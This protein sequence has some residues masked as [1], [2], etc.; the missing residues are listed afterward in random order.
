M[1]LGKRGEYNTMN[2]GQHSGAAQNLKDEGSS[3]NLVTDVLLGGAVVAAGITGI[4]FFSR[5]TST[6][7]SNERCHDP[8][9]RRARDALARM[10]VR[11][12]PPRAFGSF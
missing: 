7:A 5:P 2:D 8:H 6:S 1:A 11:A 9:R 3:L 12:A 10:W 4:V